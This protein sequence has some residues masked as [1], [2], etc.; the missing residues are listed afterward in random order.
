MNKKLVFYPEKMTWVCVLL[1]IA[2]IARISLNAYILFFLNK[3]LR[4]MIAP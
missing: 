2:V 4:H 3:R 1:G